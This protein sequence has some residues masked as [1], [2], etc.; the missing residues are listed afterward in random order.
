MSREVETEVSMTAWRLVCEAQN[1][2][3]LAKQ[4]PRLAKNESADV[5]RAFGELMVALDEAEKKVA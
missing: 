5:L 4:Y 2:T 1:F 3:A